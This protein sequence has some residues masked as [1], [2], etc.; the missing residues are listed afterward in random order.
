MTVRRPLVVINGSI[1]ELSGTDTISGSVSGNPVYSS[2]VSLDF[3]SIPIDSKVFTFSDANIT[4]ASKIYMQLLPDSNSDLDGFNCTATCTSNGNVNCQITS[5]MGR[6]VG[7]YTFIYSDIVG[8][9]YTNALNSINLGA[10]ASGTQAQFRNGT[11]SAHSTFTGA[12]S[13]ITVDSTKKIPVIHDGSTV[14][15]LPVAAP[16]VS[17][18]FSAAQYFDGGLIITDELREVPIVE[19]TST[20][21]TVD[22][23]RGTVFDLT[24]TGNCTFTFPSAT[25]GRQFTLYLTQD[26]TGSR[27]IT[28]PS[29]VRYNNNGSAPLLTTTVGSTD[30]LSFFAIRGVWSCFVGGQNYLLA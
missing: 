14:G 18:T 3:G 27:T 26:S 15:G 21:Y 5:T 13:E 24:L 23:T 6:I 10:L 20:S 28:L 11:T 30:I 4:T 19:N 22:I 9:T 29:S 1:A 7:T 25:S 12:S 2:S 8:V 16:H 17:N